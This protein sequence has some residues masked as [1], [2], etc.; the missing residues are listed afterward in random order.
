MFENRVMSGAEFRAPTVTGLDGQPPP[1]FSLS[2]TRHWSLVGAHTASL[3]ENN[4]LNTV[5][6]PQL[7]T[8]SAGEGVEQEHFAVRQGDALLGG[9]WLRGEAPNG[10]LIRVLQGDTIIASLRDV[11]HS[12]PSDL[13]NRL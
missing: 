2:R 11:F 1:S 5:V 12:V 3:D 7:V 10:I 6:S 13:C 9:L 4:Q 8:E